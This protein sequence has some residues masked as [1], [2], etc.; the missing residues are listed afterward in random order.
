MFRTSLENKMLNTDKKSNA[1]VKP[2]DVLMMFKI[3][4]LQ[5]Y[6]GFGDKQVEYQIMDRASFKTFLGLG[7]GDRV[8]DEK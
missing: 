5:R 8:P 7:T 4:I 2:Y 6:C 3:L 1:G